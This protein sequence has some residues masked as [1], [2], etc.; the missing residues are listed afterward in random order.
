MK[1][2]GHIEITTYRRRTT[3]VLRD[4][5][6]IGGQERPLNEGNCP[7]LGDVTGST[8]AKA[9]HQTKRKEIKQ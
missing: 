5:S 3:I 7:K 2:R 8:N 1:K 9:L 4:K 6:E